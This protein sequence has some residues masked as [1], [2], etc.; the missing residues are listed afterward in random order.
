MKSKMC[1]SVLKNQWR[2]AAGQGLQ[3][4]GWQWAVNVAVPLS[5]NS[6]N[7]LPWVTIL[8]IGLSETFFTLMRHQPSTSPAWRELPANLCVGEAFFFVDKLVGNLKPGD[9]SNNS[10]IYRCSAVTIM[11]FI[12]YCFMYYLTS[13]LVNMI[14][15]PLNPPLKKAMWFSAMEA[16][17]CAFMYYV[18]DYFGTQI[19]GPL[20]INADLLC[21]IIKSIFIFLCI[22]GASAIVNGL[23]H[24][25][26][27]KDGRDPS[28][29]DPLLPQKDGR[30]TSQ[31]NPSLQQEARCDPRQLIFS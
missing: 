18:A 27:Q 20:D 21:E 28:Q 2:G 30:D 12:I 22:G 5:F 7:I 25:M 17:I 14:I 8:T 13:C 4:V 10:L 31:L 3:W 23:S 24:C 11:S 16:S 19:A 26:Q 6:A 15:I 1:C 29:L 9:L